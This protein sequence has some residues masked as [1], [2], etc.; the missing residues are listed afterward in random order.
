MLTIKAVITQGDFI[1]VGEEVLKLDWNET[2]ADIEEQ[3]FYAMDG[4]GSFT[5]Y[6]GEDYGTGNV[7]KIVSH[8]FERYEAIDEFEVI[9]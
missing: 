8:I 2:C 3:E 5:V 6:R 7:G 4:S 9:N 1:M